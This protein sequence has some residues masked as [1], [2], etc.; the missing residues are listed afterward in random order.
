MSNEIPRIPAQNRSRSPQP[1]F[2]YNP[3]VRVR[4]QLILPG[5]DPI[6]A[7]PKPLHK[8][9]QDLCGRSQ[10]SAFYLRK[11]PLADPEECR[12]FLLENPVAKFANPRPYCLQIPP[13]LD[14]VGHQKYPLDSRVYA[15]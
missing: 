6:S 9:N 2:G 15:L 5:Q 12:E 3:S 11:L 14:A 10:L 13:Q 4:L 1:C 8:S 7:L